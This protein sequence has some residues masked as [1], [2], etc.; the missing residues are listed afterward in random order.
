MTPSGVVTP[1]GAVAPGGFPA[2][3]GG[4]D[5]S[6]ALTSVVPG[7][8]K[9]KKIAVSKAIPKNGGLVQMELP[10]ASYMEKAVVKITGT[11][12]AK[13]GEAKKEIEKSADARLFISR[14]EFALSGS[15]SPRVCSGIQSDVIDTLDLPATAPN[16]QLFNAPAEPGIAETKETPFEI[17]M[18][19][20]FVVS[21]QNLYGIPYLGAPST[22]P[23]FN[24][25][26]GNPNGTLAKFK[27]A[28]TGQ[29]IWLESGMCEVELWRIDLPAPVAPRL[30]SSIQNGQEVTSE[31]PGQGLY[32]ESGMIILTR[33]YEEQKPT[34]GGVK[35][36]H[37]PI[38]PDYMRIIVLVFT[39]PGVLDPETSPLLLKAELS[40]Q[41]ATVIESKKIWQFD[42][43]YRHLYNK[44]RPKGV[45][46][47]SGIDETG[48][49]SDLYVT[50]ELGNFDLE[51]FMTE[52]APG[53]E[54]TIQV[55]TQ[56]LVPLSE[57]GLYL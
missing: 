8:R 46:V 15:T 1:T 25:T 55:I 31:I 50:R 2:A 22:V 54:A 23:Q 40:V 44:T 30:V 6:G 5:V 4:V 48:T 3:A 32:Q 52:N 47:F 35:P 26:F 41:Q 53:A 24:I 56:E 9:L 29:E 57:P 42:N 18:S 19:P 17:E 13:G 39:E 43:E 7:I 16:L 33:M 51:V 28:S 37:L 20:Y 12:K 49:D 11:L 38:G 21:P 45:Y 10:K 27:A 34:K 14:F 36:F